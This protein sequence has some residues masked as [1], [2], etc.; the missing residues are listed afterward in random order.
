MRIAHIFISLEGYLYFVIKLNVI[1]NNICKVNSKNLKVSYIFYTLNFFLIFRFR[2]RGTFATTHM[3]KKQILSLSL[4]HSTVAN[5]S[6]K[7]I[8]DSD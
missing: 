6:I 3:L 8:F 5:V 1:V 4:F 2:Y 7:I